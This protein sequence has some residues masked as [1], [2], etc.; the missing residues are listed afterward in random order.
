MLRT[1]DYCKSWIETSYG[2][3]SPGEHSDT[4]GS[5]S[6]PHAPGDWDNVCAPCNY[7]LDRPGGPNTDLSLIDTDEL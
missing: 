4:V 2:E 1:C 6:D 5:E 7:G 3:V